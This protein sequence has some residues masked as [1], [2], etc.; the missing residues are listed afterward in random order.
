MISS[1][2][3]L[4]SLLG[5]QTSPRACFHVGLRSGVE[6]GTFKGCCANGLEEI[7]SGLVGFAN[8]TMSMLKCKFE[9][10]FD[11]DKKTVH[12]YYVI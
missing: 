10:H 7:T 1:C 12:L 2:N 6:G 3:R 11:V 5:L 4:T 9:N 8:V